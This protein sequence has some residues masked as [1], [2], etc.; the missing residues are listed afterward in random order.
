MKGNEASQSTKAPWSRT[1]GRFLFGAELAASCETFQTEAEGV[2]LALPGGRR[3][4]FTTTLPPHDMAPASPRHASRTILQSRRGSLDVR[5]VSV[6]VGVSSF[7][8]EKR[9]D[10]APRKLGRGGWSKLETSH[11]NPAGNQSRPV[12]LDQQPEASLAW[13]VGDYPCEA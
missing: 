3:I 5:G 1:Q 8:V 2:G 4:D 13:W 10:I 6:S 11:W 12:E 7:F 9:T